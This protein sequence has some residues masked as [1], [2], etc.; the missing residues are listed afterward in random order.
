MGLAC[1]NPRRRVPRDWY[2]A[3]D[4]FRCMYPVQNIVQIISPD[5][6]GNPPDRSL[7][8]AVKRMHWEARGGIITLTLFHA[9][10][11]VLH[12]VISLR[13]TQALVPAVVY[14]TSRKQ[15]RALVFCVKN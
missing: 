10:G 11:H 7:L 14:T 3:Y 13:P 8:G 1:Y 4:L 6:D 15:P 9:D 2:S 12:R 5:L